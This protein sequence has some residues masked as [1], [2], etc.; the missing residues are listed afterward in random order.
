M[1]VLLNASG[2]WQRPG[3]GDGVVSTRAADRTGTVC[4]VRAGLRDVPVG[5]DL[6]CRCSRQCARV[7]TPG[8]AQPSIDGVTQDQLGGSA[9][10]R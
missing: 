2:G 4:T 3:N 7:R 1:T 8:A 5:R 9:F 10:C 6:I